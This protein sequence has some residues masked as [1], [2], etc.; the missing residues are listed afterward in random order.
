MCS[1]ALHGAEFQH[2][3][4]VLRASTSVISYS[5]LLEEFQRAVPT[6]SEAD[7]VKVCNAL[8][9]S[10]SILK[11]GTVVYL[12]P[13]E[14]AHALRRVLP[15]DVQGLKSQLAE[16]E[17]KL[18]I[19]DEQYSAIQRR[20]RL[21]SRLLNYTFMAA[22]TV[23]WGL[24]F[25]LTYWELS[26]DVIEP[27]GFFVGGLTTL[28]S[29]AWFLKTR[30]DFTYE[31]MYNRF[32]TSYERKSLKQVKFDVV[33]YTRLKREVERIHSVMEAHGVSFKGSVMEAHGVS[34]EGSYSR[35]RAE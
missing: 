1:Q 7:A 9:A 8:A 34:K 30:Q 32:M 25:R 22:L 17:G 18:A 4:D 19:L 15:A 20:A 35:G 14:I 12:R 28:A 11:N 13:T 33:E 16:T 6:A 3:L 29:Y 21:R 24:L 27:V 26:W 23:Q 5:K 31:A 10:G 2:H